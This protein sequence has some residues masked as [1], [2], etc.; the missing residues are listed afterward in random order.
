[1]FLYE[2]SVSLINKLPHVTKQACTILE[3][4]GCFQQVEYALYSFLYF[5]K[6]VSQ[7][8]T[9]ASQ[10]HGGNTGIRVSTEVKQT[11]SVRDH[12]AAIGRN[13]G[14]KSGKTRAQALPASERNLPRNS[15]V[16]HG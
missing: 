6:A 2:E 3:S 16:G 10:P 11:E 8:E 1:M 13:G 14:L 7:S 15:L 9:V 12:L 4:L 5:L